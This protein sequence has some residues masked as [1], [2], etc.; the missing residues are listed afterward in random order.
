M[1]VLESKEIN[2][3]V[4]PKCSN[5]FT[6]QMI[7]PDSES[8]DECTWVEHGEPRKTVLSSIK[9]KT[10]R[11]LI[12]AIL[13]ICVFL[14]GITTAVFSE[15]F[16]D[17]SIKLTSDIGFTG[18]IEILVTDQLNNSLENINIT[19]DDITGKTNENG[20]FF[21]ENVK[22]GIQNL[23]LSSDGYITK[24]QELLIIPI[25]NSKDI[26]KMEAGVG[27]GEK[28]FFDFTGC[29]LVLAIFS[30]FALLGSITCLK[31]RHF[32]IAIAGSLMGILSFGFFFIGSILSIIAFLLIMKS[33]E[34]FENGRKGKVF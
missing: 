30:V 17:S 34:E 3:V 18:S 6:V 33:R 10:N 14:I 15:T 20:I 25:F 16:L 26:I 8:K 5:I 22:P 23:K 31:L 11:P 1:D 7:C 32:D 29:I 24:T 9:P 27:E 4:C 28:K 21:V 19:I 2:E 12:A 13:L